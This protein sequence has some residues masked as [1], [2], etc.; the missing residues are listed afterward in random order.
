MISS[1]PVSPPR[2]YTPQSSHPYTPHAQPISC[3]PEWILK[4]NS[5]FPHFTYQRC[6]LYDIPLRTL[7]LVRLSVFWQQM[8]AF[9]RFWP[10][11]YSQTSPRYPQATRL[12][13]PNSILE[14]MPTEHA[15]QRNTA[16]CAPTS[17]LRIHWC[18]P[19]TAEC[20]FC[21]NNAFCWHRSAAS[22]YL[23]CL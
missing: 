15:G 6:I 19:S 1:P 23:Q 11:C 5:N 20:S 17:R 14:V 10:P 8:D 12:G 7:R 9:C 3:S 2:P 21:G 22:R 16:A 4:A 13:G 18:K